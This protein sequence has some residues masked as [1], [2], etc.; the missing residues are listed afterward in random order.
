LGMACFHVDSCLSFTYSMEIQMLN[1]SVYGRTLIA[2]KSK[3]NRQR[4]IIS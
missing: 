2:L 3:W 4:N 1:E